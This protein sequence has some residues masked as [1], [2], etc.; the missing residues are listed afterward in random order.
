MSSAPQKYGLSL[1]GVGGLAF[2]LPSAD[3]ASFTNSSCFTGPVAA[4]TILSAVKLASVYAFKWSCVRP[5]TPSK[6]PM[7]DRPRGPSRKA[8]MCSLSSMTARV[9]F[10]VSSIFR[11]IFC[12]SFSRLPTGVLVTRSARMS[13]PC[14]RSLLQTDMV[15]EVCSRPVLTPIMA[16]MDSTSFSSCALGLRFVPVKA[17][18][19]MRC[20]APSVLVV[21]S[22]VPAL[23]KTPTEETSPKAS[24]VATLRPFGKVVITT[25]A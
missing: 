25:G 14:A 7:V 6:G 13:T 21:S 17:S 18:C 20:V 4:I 10:S 15:Y 1:P 19:S 11:R 24:L 16:P 3:V 8:H 12:F 23:R 9:G 5:S 2:T 22:R